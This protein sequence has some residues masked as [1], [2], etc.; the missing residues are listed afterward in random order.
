MAKSLLVSLAALSFLALAG[1]PKNTGV[2]NVAGTDEEQL[3]QY[4]AQLEE[5]RAKV[6]ASEPKCDEWCSLSRTVCEIS[7]NVCEIAK[8]KVDRSDV[9]SKCVGSQED[10][11]RFNDSCAS[12]KAR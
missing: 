9:Q 3:D 4:S 12:C 1:C 6:Q 7:T 5:L 10:C 11:A 8:R 2:G